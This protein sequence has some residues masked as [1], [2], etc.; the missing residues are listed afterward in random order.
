MNFKQG[1][2][3]VHRATGQ[4]VTC[5]ASCGKASFISTDGTLYFK[6]DFYKPREAIVAVIEK[7]GPR[8][9]QKPF[10]HPDITSAESE[11]RRLAEIHP[12]TEFGV[13]E[14]ISKSSAPNP[15]ATTRAT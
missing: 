13:Y 4:A 10:V 3:L 15:V 14:L 7:G 5:Y 2:R 8:P 9:S 11:A 6:D 1:D 12:G